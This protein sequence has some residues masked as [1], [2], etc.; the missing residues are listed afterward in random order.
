MRFINWFNHTSQSIQT[1][2]PEV[3]LSSHYVTE[4]LSALLFERLPPEISRTILN[5]LPD[6][7]ARHLHSLE[8]TAT[9]PENRSIG[10]PDFI[11]RTRETIGLTEIA[12]RSEEEEVALAEKIA[13][14][15]LWA[16]AQELPPD[17]KTRIE[18]NLPTELR[19]RMNLSTA[20]VEES[21][22][23]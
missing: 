14:A 20:H 11:E 21:K 16:I 10:Y 22:V 2:V 3:Q 13:D 18:E 5:L 6:D 12:P 1:R 15:F 23:A 4:R 7:G 19:S 9:S 17:L 8:S